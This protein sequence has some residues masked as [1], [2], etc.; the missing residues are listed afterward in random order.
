MD[1]VWFPRASLDLT[2]A[3]TNREASQVGSKT[4]FPGEQ[5]SVTC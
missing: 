3:K 2:P 5:E 4:D 1:Q